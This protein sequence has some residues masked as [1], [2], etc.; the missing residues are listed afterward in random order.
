[1]SSRKR[2]Q[3]LVLACLSLLL[4]AL[5]SVLSFNLGHA[6][7]EK[8]RLQQHSD[9]MAYSMAVLEARALNYFAVSNRSIAA[10][11][12]AMNSVQGYLAAATV[13]GDLMSAGKKSF[14]VVAAEEALLCV[15]CRFTCS[16]CKHIAD[17]IDVAGDF[18]DEADDYYEKAKDLDEAGSK[19]L[20]RLDDMVDA[21]HRSQRDVFDKTAAALADGSSSG[22]S[23]LRTINAPTSTQLNGGV[24]GLNKSEF[25]CVIDGKTCTG[26][27]KPANTSVKKLAAVMTEVAN[28]SRPAWAANRGHPMT[29]LNPQYMQK[30]TRGIQKQG[31]SAVQ[32]HHAGGKTAK[33][34]GDG[35][36]H[37]GSDMNNSGAVIASHEKGRVITPMYKHVVAGVGSYNTEVI[38]KDGGGSHK[39]SDAHNDSADHKFEGVNTQDLMACAAEGNCFMQ[40]RADPDRTHDF[41]QPRVYSYVT[42]KLRTDSVGK[43]PWQLNDSAKVTFKHGDQGE[44]TVELAADEGAA[45]SKALVYYHRLR[46]WKEQPNLFGPF[47]RAKLHPFA[48]GSEAANVLQKAG[49]SD[50]AEM[51]N[52][53]NIPL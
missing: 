1:M 15:A 6:L 4:L 11:Y 35:D 33:S 2:G 7:R 13:S 18:G 39:G 24:G 34:G 3:A 25:T 9:S 32:G 51:A 53:P 5:M 47:W 28:A 29:Y 36:V 44:G 20:E 16:H 38:A 40:F 27:G 31:M 19:A 48:S 14:Y 42:Q 17:A 8:T 12:A 22:L 10:S 50:S 41:G 46:S 43:A 49:N 30:L 45:V 52:A 23:K 26:T 21:I 37:S